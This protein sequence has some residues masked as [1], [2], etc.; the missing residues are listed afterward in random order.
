MS[1][2]CYLVGAVTPEELKFLEL[3]G[4]RILEAPVDMW[5]DGPIGEQTV[6]CLAIPGSLM[7]L[8]EMHANVTVTRKFMRSV[9]IVQAWSD[10]PNGAVASFMDE[11]HTLVGNAA[12]LTNLAYEDGI[13]I[14]E[15][16]LGGKKMRACRRP[17]ECVMLVYFAEQ[18]GSG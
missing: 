9:Q 16:Q 11:V 14:A 18:M 5:P 4:W 15:W 6:V 10:I 17:D 13:L 2:E 3:E 1:G 8:S 12:L 7:D